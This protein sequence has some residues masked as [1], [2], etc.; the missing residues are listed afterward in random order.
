MSNAIFCNKETGT[1]LHE[2]L[3]S[4]DD[5]FKDQTRKITLVTPSWIKKKWDE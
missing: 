4:L 2:R 5:D 3:L 1:L